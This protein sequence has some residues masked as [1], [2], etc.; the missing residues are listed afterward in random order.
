MMASLVTISEKNRVTSWNTKNS[1]TGRKNKD[2]SINKLN[3]LVF[4]YANGKPTNIHLVRYFIIT[5]TLNHSIPLPRQYYKYPMLVS[6]CYAK[7]SHYKCEPQAKLYI[8]FQSK[9]LSKYKRISDASPEHN[10]QHSLYIVLP[11]S[12]TDLSIWLILPFHCPQDFLIF[13]TEF[14]M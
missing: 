1:K 13:H 9:F 10:I 2:L 4:Y 12:I 5:L 8:L 14:L 7:P 11:L 6:T 3:T